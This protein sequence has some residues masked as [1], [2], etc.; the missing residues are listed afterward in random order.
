MTPARA[1]RLAE[2]C[3][4]LNDHK[5]NYVLVGAS[6]MQLWGYSRAS[7]DVDILIETT[8]LNVERVLTALGTLGFGLAKKWLAKS[9][10]SRR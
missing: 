7:R 6:A 2:V 1:T 8:V 10:R 5:A 9:L 3:A 4:A